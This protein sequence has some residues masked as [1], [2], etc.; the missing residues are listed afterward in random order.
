MV[1]A[2]IVIVCF[3][4]CYDDAMMSVFHTFCVFQTWCVC[5][6]LSE[7]GDCAW[8]LIRLITIGREKSIDH[9]LVELMARR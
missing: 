4:C 9:E 6:D 5:F 3:Q 7:K 1:A 8:F 2:V